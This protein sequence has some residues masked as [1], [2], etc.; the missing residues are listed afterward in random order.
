MQIRPERLIGDLREL[1]TF[2]QFKTGVNRPAFS[3][4]DIAAREWL[5]R[6]MTGIG[7]T[8]AIDA[9][10]NV[11]GRMDGAARAV[12]IGSHSDTVPFGGWLDGSLGVICALEIA[13]CVAESGN[14]PLGIDVISFQDEEGTYL[15]M[16]GSRTFCGENVAAEVAAAKGADGKSLKS[17]IA[18]AGLAQNASARLDLRRHVAYL[19]AHIEQGPRLEHA[20]RNIGVV[21][22][23]V[24]IKT[25]RVMF[26][27]QADHAGTTPMGMRRDAGAAALA[28]GAALSE[29]VRRSGSSDT[30]WNVGRT[31]FEPGAPNVVPSMAELVL[32]V[33]DPSHSVL[34]DLAQVISEAAQACASRYK[35]EVEIF[36]LLNTPPTTMSP[37]LAA[38]IAK[39]AT[40]LSASPMPMPSGAGHDAIVLA[41]YLPAAMLFVPSIAG[42]SHHI[43]EDTRE[44]DI[45]LGA[46]VLLRALELF[47]VANN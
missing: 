15:A 30:V 34:E 33:R 12:L 38:L 47:M 14:T 3:A 20:G 24:G 10:G 17:I 18:E 29:R 16:L 8:A 6:K 40:E 46:Q 44:S 32:Q 4:A 45:V 39:A 27:G 25:F 28:F 7:L 36:E 19:E 2:G 5:S 41:R 1:A 37:A 22:A 42:R 23:I 31:N 43:S 13:R 35:V 9:V 21:S 26:R 11:Y